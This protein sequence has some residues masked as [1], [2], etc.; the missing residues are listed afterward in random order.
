[1]YLV[2]T[3]NFIFCVYDSLRQR[4]LVFHIPCLQ[5]AIQLPCQCNLYSLVQYLFHSLFVLIVFVFIVFRFSCLQGGNT[6]A[7]PAQSLFSPPV[8]TTATSETIRSQCAYW[9]TYQKESCTN[10]LFVYNIDLTTALTVICVIQCHHLHLFLFLNPV[11]RTIC[12]T[13]MEQV[14]V[15]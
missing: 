14:I 2:F 6:I 3:T 1:M 13:L 11:D 7:S 12:G 4:L 15:L 10:C 5:V 8:F 9:Q